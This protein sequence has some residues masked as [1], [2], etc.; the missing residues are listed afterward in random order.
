MLPPKCA[1]P[2]C[3]HQSKVESMNGNMISVSWPP[4]SGSDDQ[5]GE[6]VSPSPMLSS[7][8]GVSP[9]NMV[10]HEKSPPPCAPEMKVGW[11]NV[12]D[13]KEG[14]SHAILF[15][16]YDKCRRYADLG[17]Q[18]DCPPMARRRWSLQILFLQ[19]HESCQPKPFHS[20]W[21]AHHHH[22]ASK[23]ENGWSLCVILD[24]KYGLSSGYIVVL[25]TAA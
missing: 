20:R 23:L 4:Q 13:R 14:L 17:M 18:H 9:S 15:S 24:D 16:T 12:H 1:K 22:M 25:P 8:W 2:R 11:M 7:K 10:T 5:H 19:N 21:M 3:L 6:W